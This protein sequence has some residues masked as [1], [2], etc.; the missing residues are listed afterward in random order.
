MAYFISINYGQQPAI[1][2]DTEGGSAPTADVYVAIGQGGQPV[3]GLS[4]DSICKLLQSIE[5]Y[6]R[7]D[8]PH[9]GGANVLSGLIP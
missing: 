2:N 3:T 4:R 6:I 8:D 7:S 1:S 5:N 9:N